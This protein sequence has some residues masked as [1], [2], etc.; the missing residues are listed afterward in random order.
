MLT[1]HDYLKKINEESFSSVSNLNPKRFIA[2]GDEAVV[3]TTEDPN[4]IVRIEYTPHTQACDKIM[5]RPDI[6]ATGGVAKIYGTKIAPPPSSIL[7]F[8]SGLF[9]SSS[10]KPVNYTYKEKVNTNWKNVLESKYGEKEVEDIVAHMHDM[11]NSE[12]FGRGFHF[13]NPKNALQSNPEFS[14]LIDAIDLGLP[15]VDLHEDNLGMTKDG[16][17][18]AIDC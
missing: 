4:I 18:V 7:S 11:S 17:I 14:N 3:Y 6:Q 12:Y 8:F 1:F 10:K 15:I 5:S 9:G 16:K 2:S 13:E